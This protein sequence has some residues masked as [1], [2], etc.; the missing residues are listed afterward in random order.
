VLDFGCGVGRLD[1][2]VAEHFGTVVGVG[3]AG[4]VVVAD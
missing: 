1:G 4:G 2:P 3:G